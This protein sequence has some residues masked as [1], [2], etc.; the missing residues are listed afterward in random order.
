[1]SLWMGGGQG[2]EERLV[3]GMAW[4]QCER[5]MWMKTMKTSALGRRGWG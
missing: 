3:D 5:L 2:T 4:E 1:M